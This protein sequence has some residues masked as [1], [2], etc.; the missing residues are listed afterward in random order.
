MQFRRPPNSNPTEYLRVIRAGPPEPFSEAQLDRLRAAVSSLGLC[1]L[2]ND[3]NRVCLTFE[4]AQHAAQAKAA[5]EAIEDG[6]ESGGEDAGPLLLP[7]LDVR[8][9]IRRLEQVCLVRP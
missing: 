8:Y 4:S 3:G 7:P 6:G 1:E 2:Q 5:L 9:C